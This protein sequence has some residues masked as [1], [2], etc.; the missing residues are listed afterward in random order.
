MWSSMKLCEEP[1]CSDMHRE[2]GG[3][4]NCSNPTNNPYN[5]A[6][7]SHTAPLKTLQK[8]RMEQKVKYIPE[9]EGR[10]GYDAKTCPCLT[11]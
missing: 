1:V 2:V 4:I 3:P 9:A 6:P 5:I 11:F 8:P 10:R 7:P